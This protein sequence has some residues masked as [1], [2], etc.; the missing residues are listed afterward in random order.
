MTIFLPLVLLSPLLASTHPLDDYY[1]SSARPYTAAEERFSEAPQ[2]PFTNFSAAY[3]AQALAEPTDWSTKGAV[4]P[5]KDQGPHGYCGTFGRVGSA[6]GQW[7]LRGGPLTSFS[8]QMLISC[9]GWDKDQYSYFAPRGF[10]T[11]ASYPCVCAPCHS[12]ACSAAPGVLPAQAS[13]HSLTP[14]PLLSHLTGTSRKQ[15]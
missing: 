8:E 12:A 2:I 9:I 10:M 4:T 5:V 7:A 1:L 14:T 13:V 6:E 11:T 3:V 15:L